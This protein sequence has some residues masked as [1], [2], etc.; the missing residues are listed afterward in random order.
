MSETVPG[1]PPGPVVATRFFS[2]ADEGTPPL[3]LRSGE[4][5]S[6]ATLAYETYGK[7]APEADN[8]VLV[9]HALS[10]SQHAAG[11]N[12]S[13]AGAADLWNDECKVGW[14]NDF[15]G[16]G[17]ALDTDRFLV[18]CANYL[19]GC[20]GSTGPR[21]VDPATGR[22]YGG[23]FP[24]VSLCDIVDSQVRLLESLGVQRLLAVTGGS[25][26]GMLA[27]TLAVRYPQRVRQ[28]VPIA[29]GLEVSTLQL[30][31]NF[32]QIFAI[33]E[34]PHFRRGNYYG[35]PPPHKGL[36]LARMIAHKTYVSLATMESRAR[37]EVL[38][39]EKNLFWYRMSHPL[40]S[41]MLHQG[42]K[43]VERFD[44]NTYLRIMD[45]WQSYDLA[46][47]AGVG[48]LESVF[49]RCRDQQYTVF[50]ID[51]D[52]CSY[53]EEQETL[54]RTLK[55]CDVPVRRITVHSEK[56]HDAFL[57]DPELFTPY[58]SYTLRGGA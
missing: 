19:G 2:L 3:V 21:S 5:L 35:H 6:R 38:G 27:L 24:R 52:V 39:P 18:V 44:A 37:N 23:R 9:F 16:P 7:L 33:E 53:P 30:I 22:P 1:T 55:S 13:V 34:D 28:V 31:H 41:Y 4:K 20:Y 14:W 11:Y 8:A 10:G 51:S 32:E 42:T 58:L 48:D 29:C 45:A 43:F 56:G 36:A 49:S 25:L 40:E 54:V 47:F 26:G 17:K 12:P 46:E 57:L 50:S 15:I